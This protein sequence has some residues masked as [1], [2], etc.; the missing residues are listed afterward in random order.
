MRILIVHN[1]YLL[2]GGEDVVFEA[3]RN[4][5]AAMGHDIE[6]VIFDN[7]SIEGR[8]KLLVGIDTLWSRS[9][10]E[11]VRHAIERHRPHLMHVHNFFPVASPSIYMEARRAGVRVLQTLHNY[12]LLCLS[13][14]FFR[15][16]SICE[17]CLQTATPLSGVRH[18]C[19][20]GNSAA[21]LISAAMLSLH[22]ARRTWHRDVDLYLALGEFGRRKLIEGGLPS[23][24]IAVKPNFLLNDPGAGNGAGGHL[25]YVGRLTENKGIPLLLEAWRRVSAPAR[26]LV[27]MGDGPLASLVRDAAAT[28][29]TI[30]YR[31]YGTP[32]EVGAAMAAAIALI[33]PSVSYE[34]Q[35]M[36]MVE[37]LA[38][39]TPI[40]A[41]DIGG[42]SEI[43][44]ADETGW[45]ISPGAA[46]LLP[47]L[48]RVLSVPDESLRLRASAREFFFANFTGEQNARA[49]QGI[50]ARLGLD[51][52]T[53]VS[54]IETNRAMEPSIIGAPL[55]ALAMRYRAPAPPVADA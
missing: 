14:D 5:L 28:D 35:G 8:N 11:R 2:R 38:R 27:V 39:G 6:T 12:R 50:F 37:A 26:R 30:E 46:S 47:A 41:F 19:Y 44:R 21:S 51:G 18:A 10:A 4:L 53:T 25:L 17:E 55:D 15:D 52:P 36:S 16:G 31:G 43:V 9:S 24:R 3:E 13:A 45:L 40:V 34:T 49:F 7:G 22:R 23:D 48:N 33:F 54:S 20:R 42:R 32:G 1:R 29:R